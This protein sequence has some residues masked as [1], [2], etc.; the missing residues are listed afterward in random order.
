MKM[1]NATNRPIVKEA[2][3][4]PSKL[5]N[6]PEDVLRDPALTEEEKKVILDNWKQDQEALLRAESEY[7]CEDGA[8]E[9]A[10]A[11]KLVQEI[12]KVKERVKP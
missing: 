1:L 4:D 8:G 9:T 10:N 12:E 7:M 6:K 2:I 5:Y 11:A 3:K